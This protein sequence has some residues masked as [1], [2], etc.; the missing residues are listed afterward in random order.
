MEDQEDFDEAMRLDAVDEM[1][2]RV[3]GTGVG[4]VDCDEKE[5]GDDERTGRGGTVL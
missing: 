1:T 5:D 2:E 3:E 4:G